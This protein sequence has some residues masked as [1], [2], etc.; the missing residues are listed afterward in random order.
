MAEKD[1]LLRGRFAERTDAGVE[2]FTA[3]VAFDRRL[4]RYDLRGSIAHAE[5]LAGAGVLTEDEARGHRGG[6]RSAWRGDRGGATSSG[7]MP[8]KTST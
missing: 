7:R 1:K 4:Y 8:S 6:A 2:Q 3:S 5:M